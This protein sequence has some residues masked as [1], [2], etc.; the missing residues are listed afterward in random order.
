MRRCILFEKADIYY[1][2]AVSETKACYYKFIAW[3]GATNQD[4]V[5]TDLQNS[6]YSI[7]D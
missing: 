7:H 4:K 3:T 5:R 2:V 1:M 6:L